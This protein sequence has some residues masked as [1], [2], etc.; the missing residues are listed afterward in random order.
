MDL[1]IIRHADAGNP[2]EWPGPDSERP[3]SS[4]GHRQ[5][6]ALGQALHSQGVTL[7]A[8]VSSPLVRARQ[9]GEDVLAA[10]GAGTALQFSDFLASGMM[11]RKKLSKFLAGLGHSSLAIVGHD[12]DLPE[13]LGFH[14]G[15]DP[16]QAHLVKGG[17]VLV[18]FDDE[19][20]KKEGELVWMV[21]PEWFMPA[22][23][24]EGDRGAP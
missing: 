5:A 21:T 1:Y 24:D 2:A 14:I 23:G 10:W 20:A 4:L 22:K 11:R 16:E 12:P 19:P 9:T 6:Q 7:G 18:R 3:L 15:T 8:V 17:A 13:Y